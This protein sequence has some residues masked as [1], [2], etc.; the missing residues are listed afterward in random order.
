V[1][2]N[3]C[4]AAVPPAS[5]E[6]VWAVLTTP[7]RFSEWNDATYVASEP[8]GPMLPGQVIHLTAP[9]FGRTWSVDI[10]VRDADAQ[11][12]WIDLRVS[13]P[14]GVVNEEHV[15]LTETKGGGTLVRFN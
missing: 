9:G 1:V 15:I 4:P 12:R 3:V 11:R 2:V 13:L 5:A 8:P 7:E 10:D 6:R 14:F